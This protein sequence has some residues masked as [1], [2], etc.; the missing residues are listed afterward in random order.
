MSKMEGGG[1]GA[2]EATFGQ[3]PKERVFFYVFPYYE[4]F[5]FDKYYL[6]PTACGIIRFGVARAFLTFESWS[7]SRTVTA[8]KLKR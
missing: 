3:C 6:N 1:G 4:M 5:D 8:R 2:V 7:S